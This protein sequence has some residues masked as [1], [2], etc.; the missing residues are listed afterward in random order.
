MLEKI[1]SPKDL[2]DL[3]I[4]EKNELAKDIRDYIMN[5]FI[6]TFLLLYFTFE[7]VK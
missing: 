2:K 6:Y 3:K 5:L 4:K 7:D 1:N